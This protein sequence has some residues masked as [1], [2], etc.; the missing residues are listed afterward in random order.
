MARIEHGHVPVLLEEIVETLAPKPG[1]VVVDCTLGRGGHALAMGRRIGSEGLIIGIDR[2]SDNLTYARSRLDEE[3]IPCHTIHDSFVAITRHL[4]KLDRRVDVI[5][6]DLG[7][8]SNQLDTSTRGFGFQDDSPLDMRLDHSG[9]CEDAQ[10]LLARISQQ[11]LTELIRTY[12][13]DPF[14]AAIARKIVI[15]RET[16]PIKTTRQLSDLVK[17]AYGPKAHS[18]RVHPATRT[19]MALRIAINEEIP[20]LETL[21]DL[22]SRGCEKASRDGWINQNARI[23]IISFHSLED[24]PVKQAFARWQKQ[25]LTTGLTSGVVRPGEAEINANPRSR[26]AKFRAVQVTGP[27]RPK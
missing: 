17:A 13:E 4:A 21:L 5:L 12:G 8:S 1:D 2:D 9:N 22:I 11:E 26:S 18:S 3:G 15:A 14:A 24:R 6:A 7:V 23:G 20:A 19:F 27:N 10:K 16:E 25:G